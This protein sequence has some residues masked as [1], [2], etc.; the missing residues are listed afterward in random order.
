MNNHR[1]WTVLKEWCERIDGKPP[2]SCKLEKRPRFEADR[3]AWWYESPAAHS[4]DTPRT[5]AYLAAYLELSGPHIPMRGIHFCLS[6][7]LHLDR[8]VMRALHAGGYVTDKRRWFILAEAGR[9]A[10]AT[11]LVQ[12]AN[13]FRRV[14]SAEQEG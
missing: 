4:P 11:W 3:L 5:L 10:V 6:G 2:S 1:A 14:I 9:D 13:K 8:A 7:Y 12:D